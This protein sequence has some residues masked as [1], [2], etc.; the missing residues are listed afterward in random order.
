MP[1]KR[2][3]RMALHAGAEL[4]HWAAC[5]EYEDTKRKRKKIIA[6]GLEFCSQTIDQKTEFKVWRTEMRK[7]ISAKLAANILL[8]IYGLLAIFHLLSQH[9]RKL[10]IRLPC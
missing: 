9:R 8:G 3:Q 1:N 10:S 7:L 4:E 6:N 5:P 2:L